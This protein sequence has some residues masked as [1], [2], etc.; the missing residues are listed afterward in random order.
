ML[1][2]QPFPSSGPKLYASQDLA[3]TA[4]MRLAQVVSVIGGNNGLNGNIDA[5]PGD[6]A[7][8][9][10]GPGAVADAGAG[11]FA[12]CPRCL[13]AP[14]K[15]NQDVA[16]PLRNASASRGPRRRL[17]KPRTD[18]APAP[19]TPNKSTRAAAMRPRRAMVGLADGLKR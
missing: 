3:P 11:A 13:A 14:P 15:L 9:G 19:S 1:Q 7:G 18:G 17:V 6:G 5:M 12:T 4:P 10:A 2:A 16:P 8:P